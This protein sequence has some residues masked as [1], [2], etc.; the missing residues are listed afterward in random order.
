[1]SD[2]TVFGPEPTDPVHV[3][4]SHETAAP[5]LPPAAASMLVNVT[6]R[7]DLRSPAAD[8][9]DATIRDTARA[10]M[11]DAARRAVESAPGASLDGDV[12]VTAALTR[13]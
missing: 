5:P 6:F 12:Q 13:T 11:C 10:L 4:I 3:S 2:M 1:M 7:V 8:A 9:D